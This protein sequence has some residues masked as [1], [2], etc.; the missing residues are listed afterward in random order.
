MTA[1]FALIA[2]WLR[3]KALA[4]AVAHW[5]VFALV[6]AGLVQVVAVRFAP[7]LE[8]PF[9]LAGPFV[10]LGLGIQIGRKYFA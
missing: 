9:L 2:T 4:F 5:E 7:G 3:S 6:F 10:G 1:F 8:R